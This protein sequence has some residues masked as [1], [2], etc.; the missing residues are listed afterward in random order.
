MAYLKAC[1]SQP[2]RIGTSQPQVTIGGAIQH[3]TVFYKDGFN[4][5][6]TTY[7]NLWDGA[8]RQPSIENADDSGEMY[9]P[10]Y[11]TPVEK[12][13]YDPSPVGFRIPCVAS[14][15]DFE[16]GGNCAFGTDTDGTRR[17]TYKS[18]LN[19][20]LLGDC[21]GESG[22]VE[23]GFGNNGKYWSANAMASWRSS[24]NFP[25]SPL[26]LSAYDRLSD[27]THNLV[28]VILA[29]PM[30]AGDEFYVNGNS[31]RFNYVT[32]SYSTGHP[33]RPVANGQSTG[34]TGGLHGQRYREGEGWTPESWYDEN[35]NN[36][37]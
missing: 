27:D 19:F 9:N 29:A 18:A 8:V 17:L 22:A 31:R 6:S 23:S 25:A 20:Y 2:K 16:R 11:F 3:P 30:K 32:S 12:T 26:C 15:E 4:W 10:Y 35:G 1:V 24:E 33:V 21:S 5:C 14:W 28:E 7:Y 36:V 34:V 13:I 37:N